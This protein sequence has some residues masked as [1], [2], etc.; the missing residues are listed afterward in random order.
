MKGYKKYKG[1]PSQYTFLHNWVRSKLGFPRRCKIC[2][3]DNN[4]DWANISQEY[5]KSVKD[6]IT[7]CRKCHRRFDNPKFWKLVGK[8]WYKLCNACKNILKAETNFYKRKTLQKNGCRQAEYS[9]WCK[10]CTYSWATE[11]QKRKSKAYRLTHF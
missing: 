10:K 6:W 5:K 3:S 2:K 9:V 8:D 4:V 7:L 11:F 1:T